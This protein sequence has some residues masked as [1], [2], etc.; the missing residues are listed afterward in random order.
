MPYNIGEQ[1]CLA[2]GVQLENGVTSPCELVE[3]EKCP[4]H[5]Q[6][7]RKNYQSIERGLQNIMPQVQ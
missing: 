1:V 3:F 6:D 5:I 7:L 2:C 4:V